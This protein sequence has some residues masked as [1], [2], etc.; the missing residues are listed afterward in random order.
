MTTVSALDGY[1]GCSD[2]GSA[3]VSDD[4]R[5]NNQ[6]ANKIALQISQHLGMLITV[7]LNLEIWNGVSISCL[8]LEIVSS[9]HFLHGFLEL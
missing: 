2:S 6:V 1:L 5:D 7:N 8:L 4:T 9:V 3:C